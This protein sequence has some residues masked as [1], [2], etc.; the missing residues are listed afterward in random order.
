MA[1]SAIP[2]YCKRLVAVVTPAARKPPLHIDHGIAPVPLFIL[3]KP[4]MA[5]RAGVEGIMVG[6]A[7]SGIK[8]K[9]D[10][11]YWMAAAATASDAE[12][13]FPVMTGSARFTLLHLLHGKS[14]GHGAG[15]KDPEMAIIAPE[16]LAAVIGVAE[17]HPPPLRDLPLKL[18]GRGMASITTA[19]GRKGDISLMA[20]TA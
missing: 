3:E 8:N 15:G 19:V 4:V 11:P 16:F 6:M 10:L 18:L 9:I 7:E 12:G 13:T 20:G 2:C 17:D 1:S 5:G 14:F